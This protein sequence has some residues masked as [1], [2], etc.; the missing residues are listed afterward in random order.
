MKP[1]L[2]QANAAVWRINLWSPHTKTKQKNRSLLVRKDRWWTS[3][4]CTP[5]IVLQKQ[6]IPRVRR[7]T[8]LCLGYMAMPISSPSIIRKKIGGGVLLNR[9]TANKSGI[10]TADKSEE[11]KPC[12]WL[13]EHTCQLPWQRSGFGKVLY[14]SWLH[15]Q[16]LGGPDKIISKPLEKRTNCQ[17]KSGLYICSLS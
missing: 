15:H 16:W 13:V 2:A 1:V 9:S 12:R 3:F 14:S 6:E 7:K 4:F 5:A 10:W 17:H 8:N 11:M